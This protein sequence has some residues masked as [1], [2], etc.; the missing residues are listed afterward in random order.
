MKKI[1]GKIYYGKIL[2]N[3]IKVENL[4]LSALLSK[5]K[6]D[7]MVISE[8]VLLL[9]AGTIGIKFYEDRFLNETEEEL[10][11]PICKDAW[12]EHI[13]F[14]LG[15]YLEHQIYTK[16][17]KLV[18][19][20]N[21]TL[22]LRV[23]PPM[24]EVSSTII[25][26]CMISAEKIP[27]VIVGTGIEKGSFIFINPVTIQ[28]QIINLYMLEQT[29]VHLYKWNAPSYMKSNYLTVDDGVGYALKYLGNKWISSVSESQR[30]KT[31]MEA[32]DNLI[33]YLYDKKYNKR[34][35]K[36]IS[37]SFRIYGDCMKR[38]VLLH[39]LME[40][41]CILKNSGLKKIISTITVIQN[42]WKELSIIMGKDCESEISII[43]DKI[44][45]IS[46]L[47]YVLSLYMIEYSKKERNKYVT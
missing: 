20:I 19:E 41:D 4:W 11:I 29:C 21:K 13:S 8:W 32:Y 23:I 15:T 37:E 45:K 46:Y 31:G 47:E 18:H 1:D 16:I 28:Y 26:D 9:Y 6:T 3:T 24:I 10:I 35:V 27:V 22:R 14:C 2:A 38:D 12:Q 25:S 5:L 39:M 33:Y 17:D 30:I 40:C 43:I 7:G 44:K 36:R 34:L 42:A